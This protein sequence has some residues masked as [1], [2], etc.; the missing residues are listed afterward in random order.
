MYNEKKLRYVLLVQL[1]STNVNLIRVLQCDFCGEGH[2][3]DNCKQKIYVVETQ[4]ARNYHE[5][6]PSFNTYPRWDKNLSCIWNNNHFQ[7]FSPK[8]PQN[9]PLRISSQLEESLTSFM[10]AT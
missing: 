3:N 5:P 9:P 4:Y 6:K 1:S 2:Q 8:A 10:Q 7:I